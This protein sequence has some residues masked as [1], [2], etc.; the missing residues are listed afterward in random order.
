MDATDGSRERGCGAGRDGLRRERITSAIL[1]R[2]LRQE[3]VH[4]C[5]LGSASAAAV[6]REKVHGPWTKSKGRLIGLGSWL[7][8]KPG[9]PQL[10][11]F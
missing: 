1:Q 8:L 4:K 9:E 11:Y 7:S 5:S 3:I 6:R 10:C 2:K